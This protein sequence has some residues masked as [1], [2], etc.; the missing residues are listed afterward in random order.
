MRPLH[1]RLTH[2]CLSMGT[3]RKPHINVD[4]KQPR[5]RH[6][7]LATAALHIQLILP[8]I[9]W[10]VFTVFSVCN[11]L[12]AQDSRNISMKILESDADDVG[13][14]LTWDVEQVPFVV[15][16]HELDNDPRVLAVVLQA[17]D[18]H[19]VAQVLHV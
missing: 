10:P 2:G 15:V 19:Y 5:K 4:I 9:R 11:S 12:R 7:S 8:S 1:R 13:D 18:A 16:H 14:R 6:G 17:D 3:R